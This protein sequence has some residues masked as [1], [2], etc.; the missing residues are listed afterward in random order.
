MSFSRYY[1][2]ADIALVTPLKDGMNLVAKEFCAAQIDERGVLIVSEFAGAGPELRIGAIVVNPNDYA[3]VAQ[4]LYDAAHMS[5][6]DK[7]SRM[8]LLRQIVK[9]HNVHLWIR[10]FLHAIP[11]FDR[12]KVVPRG[13]SWLQT[14]GS[15]VRQD[16]TMPGVA[17]VASA[18]PP[19]SS[20][21]Y[22]MG[23]DAKLRVL[24][25]AAGED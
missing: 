3:E 15:E 9:D 23:K 24:G 4:A 17:L 22:A 6:E 11:S 1:R 13:D 25:S 16:K 19:R 14:A 12:T 21:R 2:A 7:R 10:S 8:R 18:L 5:A 20:T